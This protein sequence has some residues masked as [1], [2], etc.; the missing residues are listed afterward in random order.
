M[1]E[2][3]PGSGEQDPSDPVEAAFVDSVATEFG[4]SAAELR[5]ERQSGGHS[6]ATYVVRT[7]GAPVV[8]RRAPT[9]AYL[10]TAHDVG[11]EFQALTA[12]ALT[13]VPAPE[14]L[15]HVRSQAGPVEIEWYA[16]TFVEGVVLSGASLRGCYSASPE[17]RRHLGLDVARVL[18]QLH[19]VD[20]RAA[21]LAH[22]D[23]PEPFLVRQLR[24]W[25]GQME[26]ASASADPQVLRRLSDIGAWLTTNMPSN[27]KS[28]LVHGDYK[29]N[30]I[31]ASADEPGRVLAVL[32]W[33]MSAIGDPLM[34]VGWLLWFWE[35]P[36]DPAR[37][38]DS[39]SFLTRQEGFPS[40]SALI[41][42]YTQTTGATAASLTYYE[43]FAVWKWLI[44]GLGLTELRRRRGD[45]P[46]AEQGFA[47]GGSAAAVALNLCGQ[48]M[49]DF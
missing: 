6:V 7:D 12:L 27:S 25:K 29:L 14:P 15:V 18:G 40:R 47:K 3:V 36:E 5:I 39:P 11:R 45:A 43:T 16:M 49:L 19:G 13:S 48:L 37:G 44:I 30:N 38:I 41:D 28:S 46:P 34:D 20:W 35:E 8:V 22:W 1:L 33:E 9:G 24:R 32:D 17:A 2:A 42:A 4:L 26:R 23:R 21:G 10:P 31:L